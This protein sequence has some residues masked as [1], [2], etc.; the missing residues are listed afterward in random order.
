[1]NAIKVSR[2]TL[3]RQAEFGSATLDRYF[4]SDISLSM[5][6]SYVHG[7]GPFAFENT[8]HDSICLACVETLSQPL[9]TTWI[10]NCFFTFAIS[11]PRTIKR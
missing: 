9:L 5:E 10:P 1:M 3:S 2:R 6:L 4:E 7:Q 11:W 8:I